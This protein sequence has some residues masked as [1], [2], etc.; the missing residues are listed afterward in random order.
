MV[1]QIARDP[2]HEVVPR[3]VGEQERLRRAEVRGRI[4]EPLDLHAAMV[5]LLGNA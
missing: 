2:E 4:A 5:Y 1:A 3:L